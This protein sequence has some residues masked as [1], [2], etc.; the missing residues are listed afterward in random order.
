M[1]FPF[2]RRWPV[3]AAALALLPAAVGC[4]VKLHP[5][6]GQVTYPD[7]KPV[8]EGVVVFEGQGQ[9]NRVTA[10]GEIQADGR[11]ELSTFKPGDGVPPGRYRVLVA[12]RS[13]PN[14]VDRPNKPPP[15]DPRFMEFKTSGL[16]IEVKPEM[17]EYPIQ[18]TRSGLTSTRKSPKP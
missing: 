5:V 18:V 11:Y 6:R 16:E 12:P 10:R 14:A 4:G 13:D 7:G 9:E 8:S 1:G 3:V 15:F 2:L 17:T